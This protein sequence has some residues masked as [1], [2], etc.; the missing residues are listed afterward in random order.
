[1]LIHK[2]TYTSYL[3]GLNDPGGC[4]LIQIVIKQHKMYCMMNYW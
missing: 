2:P 3:P 1:M 4:S